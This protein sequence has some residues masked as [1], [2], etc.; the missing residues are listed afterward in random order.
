MPRRHVGQ[1]RVVS[2]SKRF[3]VLAC[4]RR[5][6]KTKLGED[7]I[8]EPAL[9]GYPCGW[10]SPT[11]KMLA[12]V[13]REL[14]TL[15]RP[16]IS[17][18]NAQEHRLELVTGGQIEMWSLDTPDVARGRKYK[19]IIVDEAAMVR[20]LQDA[21]QAV[22]RP[23][24]IDFEGGAWFLS[25]PKGMNF[26]KFLFDL[27]QDPAQQEWASWRLPTRGNPH[28]QESEIDAMRLTTPERTFQ[29]EIEAEFLEFEGAVFRRLAEAA[30]AQPLDKGVAGRQYVYGVDW[31]QTYD[32]TVITVLDPVSKQ[33]VAMDRF[34]EIDYPFQSE[35]L[36]ALFKRFPPALVVAEANSMGRPIIQRLQLEGYPIE[37][38][39]TTPAS[40][41]VLIQTLA[42]AFERGLL[43]IIND[44]VLIAEL[45]AYEATKTASGRIAY[46]APEGQHDDCVVSLALAWIALGDEAPQEG[47]YLYDDRVAIS[48]F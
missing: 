35:R 40:K 48:P 2:E 3:N 36:K 8:V 12:E 19:R 6:G 20:G 21:W 44:P 46:S 37:P 32:F 28:I 31:A 42:L 22:L 30:T 7:R 47:Q 11:Y 34:N 5:W 39:D 24:L 14:V 45:Q 43:S 41:P 17:R 18:V 10:F 13:W 26:F 16:V 25:T 23:T 4:G 9:D 27:G 33:M 1:E 29:Q 38:F 15:L